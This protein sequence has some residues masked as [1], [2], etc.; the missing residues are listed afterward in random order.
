MIVEELT[1]VQIPS[2]PGKRLGVV[3]RVKRWFWLTSFGGRLF[4]VI[5]L[6]TLAGMG[7]MAFLFSEMLRRQAEDQVRSS[8]DSKVNAIASVTESA[9]TL[10]YS[11][12]VSAVTLNE[13]KAQY[14]DTYRELVLQL[15][16]Q[17]P[18]FVVGLGLGQA[19][20][21]IIENQPWLFP[22]YSVVK[23]SGTINP[24]EDTIR[25]E[26]LADN[27]GEFYPDSK[28]YQIY[29]APQKNV[30][31]AP[32]SKDNTRQLTYYY[33]LFNKDGRWIGTTL[34]D[35]DTTYLSKLLDDDVFQK[36][37]N[38]LLLTRS[39]LLIADPTNPFT[40]V[41]NYKNIAGI[42]SILKQLDQKESG[43]FR[44]DTGYWAY[45]TVPGKDW[46]LLGFVPHG[47]IFGRIVK[48]TALITGIIG[49]LIALVIYLAIRKL[50]QRIKPILL[51]A[52]QFVDND[53]TLMASFTR[54]DELEQL[55]LSFFNMLNQLNQHQ[56]TIYDQ[57]DIIA[58]KDLH[59]DQVTEKF[60]T[61]TT[62]VVG[63][64]DKQQAL[65]KN[66]QRQLTDQV[67][68]Y[69]SINSQLNAL[70]TLTQ[71]LRRFLESIPTEAEAARLFD[72]LDQCM[73]QLTE[74]LENS[75]QASQVKAQPLMT[76]LITDI[77][78]LK[79][80]YR[81]Q[82][83]LEQLQLQT[84]NISEVRQAT[85]N[86]S[87]AM[88][89]AVAGNDQILTEIETI[90]KTLTRDAQQLLDTLWGD[91]QQTDLLELISPKIPQ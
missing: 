55:S 18:E 12:G 15:F 13:R 22:Y 35:I 36:A 42:P 41:E 1:S 19:K 2:H 53:E 25:Y 76:R 62:Q 57:A 80:Y 43:F 78:N 85:I 87:E 6:G 54:H 60:L 56:K 26:N 20:N 88:V 75:S 21:G 28:R 68:D 89:T 3:S 31:T 52:N 65:I 11:L 16:E 46:V 27:V 5:M 74:V 84:N 72:S 9:E 40:K 37:G 63:D 17:R 83:V 38:F 30:W 7:S 81:Q 58:Q 70:F 66:M 32:Y 49:L 39:G 51:Q 69:Q 10:A 86:K 50:N 8:I 71:M 33:P 79:V 24:D 48:T 73:S 67:N 44:G 29:F 61:F 91:L 77:A 64:A 34:V 45:A 82:Y 23:S 47:A 59:A 90:T 4:W 14:A